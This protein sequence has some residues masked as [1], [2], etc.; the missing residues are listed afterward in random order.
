MNAG[1]G[2]VWWREFLGIFI[3]DKPRTILY[4]QTIKELMSLANG[5]RAKQEL[6]IISGQYGFINEAK[7]DWKFVDYVKKLAN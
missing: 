1:M 5:I 7:V 6:E 3:L 4:N 2:R